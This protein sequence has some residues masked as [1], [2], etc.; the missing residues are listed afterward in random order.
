MKDILPDFR[1]RDTTL[2]EHMTP[3]DCLSHR[4]GMQPSNYWL[5]SDN[6]ILIAEENSMDVI[7][8]L[9][10]VAPF[11]N[12]YLYNNHGY[13]IAG[14]ILAK[15]SGGSWAKTLHER[16]FEPL[17]MCRTGTRA[18]FDHGDN[19]AK[20]YGTLDDA[21]NVE[22][23]PMLTGE[24]T[25]GG[26]GSAMRSCIRDLVKMYASLLAAGK[27][28]LSSGESSTVGSPF[29]QVPYLWSPK[30]SM[31][32]ISLHE[33]TYA[34][35]WLRVQTPGPMEVTGVN[36][37]RLSPE[38]APYLARDHPS[39]L[40]LYHP[41]MM[42]GSL[43]AVILVPSTGGA[44]IVLTNSLALSTETAKWLSQ[45]YLE[46]YLG[47]RN[48]HDYVALAKQGIKKA[49]EWH[50]R[51]VKKLAATQ[52]P[53]TNARALSEYTGTFTNDARTMM[54]RVFVDPIDSSLKL[55]FQGLSSEIFPLSHYHFDVFTWLVSRDELARR[56]RFTIHNAEYFKISFETGADG[57]HIQHLTWWHN[58]WLPEPER[59]TKH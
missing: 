21:S 3:V 47:V 24:N 20:T 37:N 6:N 8:D 42:P 26:P 4:A 19:N 31:S 35:G 46:A 54:I 1:T 27:H 29:K 41:G 50:P 25:V 15:V 44:I 14:H 5:G 11:R 53:G 28:Q 58:K 2:H 12:V 13:E 16:I 34:L 32:S 36:P 45:L 10:R 40:V 39:H 23:T 51:L 52:T 43:A 33:T 17:E 30:I 48:S 49:L 59:L 38:A 57:N 56:G 18:F 22:I 9:Q 55:S 7:N